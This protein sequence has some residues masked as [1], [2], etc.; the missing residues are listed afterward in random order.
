M[1]CAEQ[2]LKKNVAQDTKKTD[3]TIHGIK[4]PEPLYTQ[5]FVSEI[6]T[7]LNLINPKK[8]SE[9]LEVEQSIRWRRL[10]FTSFDGLNKQNSK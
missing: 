5:P 8:Q 9:K 3:T 2:E 4:H 6:I 1:A 7:Q 10:K